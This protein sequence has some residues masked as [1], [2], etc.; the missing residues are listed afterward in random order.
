MLLVSAPEGTDTRRFTFRIEQD[1]A[2]ATVSMRCLDNRTSEVNGASSELQFQ[3]ISRTVEVAAGAVVSEPLTCGVGYKG[4]VA[5]WEYP[6][7][8]VPLGNDPQPITRVF[9]VWNSTG[10]PQQVTLHLLCLSLNTEGGGPEAKKFVNTAF[11]STTTSQ[12]PGAVLSD[13]AD[14]TVEPGAPAPVLFRASFSGASLLFNAGNVDSPASAV[15]RS[16]NAV[17]KTIRFGSVIGRK[18]LPN[19]V[20]KAQVR[21]SPKA[22]RAIRSGSLKRVKL[23]VKTRDGG[24]SSRTVRVSG[25]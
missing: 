21:L 23:T 15:V 20:R 13:S 12:A 7:G 14:V 6:E 8:V 24:S 9:K 10:L 16:M 19:G 4:I 22:V 2:S 5:G 11:V 3:P 25:R 17:G 18:A 1:G